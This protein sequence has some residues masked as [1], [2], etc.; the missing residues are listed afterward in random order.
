M[1]D[2]L[3]QRGGV[4]LLV[5][6]RSRQGYLDGV[7]ADRCRARYRCKSLCQPLGADEKEIGEMEKTGTQAESSRTPTGEDVSLET[8]GDQ[9]HKM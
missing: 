9:R 3:C 1:K 4:R 5:S 6:F 8:E 7:P 2:P